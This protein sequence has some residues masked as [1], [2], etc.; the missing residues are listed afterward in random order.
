MLR[1]PHQAEN[2]HL[3]SPTTKLLKTTIDWLKAMAR[4]EHADIAQDIMR[5]AFGGLR[6]GVR[7][8]NWLGALPDV[9]YSCPMVSALGLVR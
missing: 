2:L 3:G 9:D 6:G 4:A 8:G 1:S 7:K 5:A